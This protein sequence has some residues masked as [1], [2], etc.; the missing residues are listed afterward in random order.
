M[1]AYSVELKKSNN[2]YSIISAIFFFEKKMGKQ[3]FKTIRLFLKLMLLFQ[4]YSHHCFKAEATENN[5][6]ES[7]DESKVGE[8]TVLNDQI[9]DKDTGLSVVAERPKRPAR[10]LPLKIL[11]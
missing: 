1:Y 9:S 6:P 11:R 8:E 10:L 5:F 3:R 7:F 2:K 4:I